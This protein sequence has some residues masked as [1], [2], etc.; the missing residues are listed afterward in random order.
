M[1]QPARWT[2]MDSPVKPAN[3]GWE[4]TA[5]FA[6]AACSPVTRATMSAMMSVSW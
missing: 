6:Y 4:Q 1:G 2:T 5:V 3:D